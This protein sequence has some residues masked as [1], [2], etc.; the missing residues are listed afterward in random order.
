VCTD[1]KET[2]DAIDHARERLHLRA[3]TLENAVYHPLI[4]RK[5]A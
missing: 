4:E 3:E 5:V 2:L 1:Q